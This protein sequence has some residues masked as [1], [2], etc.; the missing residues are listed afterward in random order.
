MTNSTSG[1]N[2]VEYIQNMSIT[3]SGTQNY[4]SAND[5]FIINI[6]GSGSGSLDITQLPNLDSYI[7][8]QL[9]INCFTGSGKQDGIDWDYEL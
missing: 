8:Y 6:Q 4:G 9:D 5:K 3:L 7:D 1:N 2:P